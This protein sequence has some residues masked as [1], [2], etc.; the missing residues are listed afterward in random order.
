MNQYKYLTSELHNLIQNDI[1]LV[2]KDKKGK[3]EERLIR[4]GS[5]EKENIQLII[6]GVMQMQ[7]HLNIDK[8]T[9]V[10]ELIERLQSINHVAKE[11]ESVDLNDLSLA[12]A[13]FLLTID[14]DFLGHKFHTEN[15]LLDCQ[16]M[17]ERAEQD[18][19]LEISIKESQRE[20]GK[21][22]VTERFKGQDI[23]VSLILEKWM[24]DNKP[25]IF[26]FVQVNYEY[27]YK[28]SPSLNAKVK[29]LEQMYKL[30]QDW[31][32]AF[33]NLLKDKKVGRPRKSII[34]LA[35]KYT[36]TAL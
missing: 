25:N 22:A 8:D 28:L 14:C 2:L 3:V 5:V 7:A 15:V 1:D 35:K 20:S 29:S 30:I 26:H 31:L 11:Q 36:S 10:G 33:D 4:L 27:F 6:N 21:L 19:I 9:S 12:F 18:L 34:E 13:A 23:L 17:F 32:E 24:N 16:K